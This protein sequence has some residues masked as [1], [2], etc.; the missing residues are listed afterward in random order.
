MSDI[1]FQ[2]VYAQA[3]AQQL[4]SLNL[5]AGTTARQALLHTLEHGLVTLETA[6]AGLDPM[7][8]P[9]GVFAERVADDH[10]LCSGERL[11]IYRPLLR[12]PMERRRR[13][14]KESGKG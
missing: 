11:E 2:V 12:D 8:L 13:V 5:P 10:V 4:I 9:L 6:D 3:H 14:A 7:D 1:T